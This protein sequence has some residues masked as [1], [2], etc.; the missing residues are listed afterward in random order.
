MHPIAIV[1]GL[2]PGLTTPVGL[3]IW[4]CDGKLLSVTHECDLNDCRHLIVVADCLSRCDA[5]FY[6]KVEKIQDKNPTSS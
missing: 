6:P 5:A 2:T 1:A 3:S 4:H